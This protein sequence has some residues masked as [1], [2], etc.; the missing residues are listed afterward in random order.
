MEKER[1]LVVEEAEQW[2]NAFIRRKTSPSPLFFEYIFFCYSALPRPRWHVRARA[3]NEDACFL[4]VISPQSPIVLFFVWLSCC[5]LLLLLSSS[6]S[7]WM[8]HRCSFCL[9]R[10]SSS[11]S[12][13]ICWRLV[14][15][16]TE[17][18][19]FW[20]QQ[21]WWRIIKY[22]WGGGSSEG[23]AP[24]MIVFIEDVEG[25]NNSKYR[26]TDNNKTLSDLE[27]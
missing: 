24:G 6:S 8:V 17:G 5:L 14:T 22:R 26:G 23:V 21:K 18:C 27:H 19:P 11:T 25:D 7:S 2:M 13:S 15:A 9:S 20:V 4:G 10:S 12:S 3:R 1:K 16:T